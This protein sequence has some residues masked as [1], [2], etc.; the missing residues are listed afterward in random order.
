MSD[1]TKL[2]EEAKAEINE[3]HKAEIKRKLKDKLRAI[4]LARR[5]LANLEGE[6]EV[7]VEA[8]E[9]ECLTAA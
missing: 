2:L 1:I 3:Q 9:E 6:L 7:L 4:V 8:S 5:V